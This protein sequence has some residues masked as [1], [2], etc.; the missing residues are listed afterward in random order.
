MR[1]TPLKTSLLLLL[2]AA[3]APAWAQNDCRAVV[4]PKSATQIEDTTVWRFEFAVTTS[5]EHSVGYFEYTFKAGGEVRDRASP[6]WRATDG[7]NPK[8]VDEHDVG[9]KE[10]D[11]SSLAIKPGSIRSTKQ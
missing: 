2:T 7:K 1:T 3:C 8:V 6:T 9:L 10:I 4:T 11:R 5:C